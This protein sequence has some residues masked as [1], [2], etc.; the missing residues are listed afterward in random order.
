M[1]KKNAGQGIVVIGGQWG[2]EGK[3]ASLILYRLIVMPQYAFTVVIMQAILCIL[4][5]N[6]WFCILYPAV[7]CVLEI[8]PLSVME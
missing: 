5:A 8:L 4:M 2:D 6:H 1:A 7:S 3:G